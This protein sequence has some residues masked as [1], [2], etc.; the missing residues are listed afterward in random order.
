[1]SR[2]LARHGDAVTGR[3]VE[4]YIW[5]APPGIGISVS[6]NQ[7]VLRSAAGHFLESGQTGDRETVFAMALRA[8]R[9]RAN[10]RAIGA[11]DVA[12]VVYGGVLE[13]YTA[14]S[15]A[16]E[17]YTVGTNADWLA[18][19]LLLAFEPAGGRY[20]V[21]T[22]LDDLFGHPPYIGRYVET[23]SPLGR[24]MAIALR[25]F[26]PDGWRGAYGGLLRC[27]MVSHVA[28][29]S[30]RASGGSPKVSSTAIVCPTAQLCKG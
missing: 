24:G 25:G 18:E 8:E 5:R 15:G 12:A 10:G 28:R 22:L 1:M 27:S 26:D 17:A 7:A 9:E 3:A 29:T 19:R 23:I 14:V 2:T 20:D 11:Q 16:V 30:V 13:I 21:P 6:S 4:E